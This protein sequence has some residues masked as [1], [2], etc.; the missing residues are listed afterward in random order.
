MLFQKPKRS[1]YR[2]RRRGQPE[3]L[4]AFLQFTEDRELAFAKHLHEQGCSI[5]QSAA[6]VALVKATLVDLQLTGPED[7]VSK[8]NYVRFLPSAMDY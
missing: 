2:L 5:E 8:G 6:A 3:A 4:I 7:L 1:N